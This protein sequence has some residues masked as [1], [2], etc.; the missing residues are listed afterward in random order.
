MKQEESADRELKEE[1]EK[2]EEE[3]KMSNTEHWNK[4]N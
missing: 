2:V 3:R 1:A 4:E